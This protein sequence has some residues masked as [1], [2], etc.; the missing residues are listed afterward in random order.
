MVSN[1][2]SFKVEMPPA[3]KPKPMK[4]RK[5]TKLWVDPFTEGESGKR[6]SENAETWETYL[7]ADER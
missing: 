6:E 3:K 1:W 2:H 5:R 7:T 4:P